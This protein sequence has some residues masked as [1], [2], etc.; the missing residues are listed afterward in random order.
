[1]I[2]IKAQKQNTRLKICVFYLYFLEKQISFYFINLK[3]LVEFL[4]NTFWPNFE[5]EKELQKKYL[6][7]MLIDLNKQIKF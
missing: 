6:I 2:S 3:T 5:T 1:M 7:K 4:K